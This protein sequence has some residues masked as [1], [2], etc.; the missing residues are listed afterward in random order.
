MKGWWHLDNASIPRYNSNHHEHTIF[1]GYQLTKT[2]QPTSP[3][4]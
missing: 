3:L 1:Y 4:S 2:W